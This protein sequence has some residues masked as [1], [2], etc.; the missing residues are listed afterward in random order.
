M[1]DWPR[2]PECEFFQSMGSLITEGGEGRLC[3]GVGLRGLAKRLCLAW[4]AGAVEILLQPQ[5]PP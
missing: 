1:S 4:I 2:I 5:P 3:V